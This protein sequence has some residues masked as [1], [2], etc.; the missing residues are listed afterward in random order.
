MRPWAIIAKQHAQSEARGQATAVFTGQTGVRRAAARH[1]RR[2][3]RACKGTLGMAVAA[4]RHN[5]ATYIRIQLSETYTHTLGRGVR[6]P[7][8]MIAI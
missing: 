7:R 6:G 5:G 2:E 4:V 3:A 1:A 8:T